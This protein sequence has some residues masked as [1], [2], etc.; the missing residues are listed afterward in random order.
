MSIML[1]MTGVYSDGGLQKVNY[2]KLNEL[3]RSSCT[4]FGERGQIFPQCSCRNFQS[5]T[6]DRLEAVFLALECEEAFM[7]KVMVGM[8]QRNAL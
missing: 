5:L 3:E 1:G 2:A 4:E 7:S 8:C 6:G